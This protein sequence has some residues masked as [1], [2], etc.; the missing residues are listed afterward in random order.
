MKNQRYNMKKFYQEDNKCFAVPLPH[1]G[2][3]G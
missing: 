2:S 1:V 3:R